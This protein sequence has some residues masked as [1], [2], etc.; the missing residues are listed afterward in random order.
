M[1]KQTDRHQHERGGDM[2]QV[3]A[4]SGLSA[5]TARILRAHARHIQRLGRRVIGDVVEIGR[6]LT[7]AKRRL[8]HGKFLVWLAAEFGWSERTVENFMRVYD[9]QGK[10]AN[11]ADLHVPLSALY[12]LA[13]PSVPDQALFAVAARAG[14]GAGLSLDEVK[15]IIANSRRASPLRHMI[16]LAKQ[17]LR[18][19]QKD[20]SCGAAGNVMN[21]RRARDLIDSRFAE[22]KRNGYDCEQ[23]ELIL[24]HQCSDIM[25]TREEQ[26]NRLKCEIAVL[27]LIQDHIGAPRYG[28][29]EDARPQ[30]AAAVVTAPQ[31]I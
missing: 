27:K 14:N 21:S 1:S 4:V 30:A 13:A 26:I 25:G 31:V 22:L 2:A 29:A 10:F 12:L 17:I 24:W 15:E 16:H 5:R 18:E 19:V 8:G 6:R 7:D 23:I 3:V 9:L 11:F 28:L 20:T